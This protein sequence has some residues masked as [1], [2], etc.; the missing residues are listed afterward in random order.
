MQLY[1]IP[2]NFPLKFA[3]WSQTAGFGVFAGRAF[4]KNELMPATWKTLFL[5]KNFPNSQALRHY[6]S[7]YNKTHMGLPLDYGPVFNHHE[8]ANVQAS[9]APRSNNIYYRVRMGFVCANRNVLK[10]CSMHT[11]TTDTRTHNHFQGHKR[12]CG[13]TGSFGPVWQCKVVWK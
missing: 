1:V 10:I 5:P 13:W 3:P 6:V 4:K 2:M 7:G 8:N 11:Y 9:E 12:H